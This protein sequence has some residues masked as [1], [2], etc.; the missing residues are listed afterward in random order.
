MK[1]LETDRLILRD[2]QLTDLEDLYTYA[3]EEG[4]GE[5]A[6]WPHHTDKGVSEKILKGFIEQ[7]DVYALEYKETGHVIGSLGIHAKTMDQSYKAEVQR[8]IG[9]VM[10]KDYWGKGLMSEA[11]AAAITYAFET[12][13]VDVLWC[14]YF[15]DNERSRRVV[16]KSGFSYYGEGVYE[17]H[18]LEKSFSMKQYILTKEMYASSKPQVLLVPMTPM[19]FQAYKA[20]SVVAYA[21]EKVIA[22]NWTQDEALEKAQAEYNTLLPDNE[23]TQGHYLWDIVVASQKV[24][25]LWLGGQSDEVAF[26]YAIDVDETYRRHGYARQAM[27]QVE[28]I[29][30]D[31]GFKRIGLHVFGSNEKAI[32]LYTL[33]GYIPTNIRMEKSIT[34]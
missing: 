19:A 11:V 21:K 20:R 30:R 6:G 32:A 22:G 33:L 2:W 29:A 15:T 7:G 24:G 28:C 14:G 34:G 13:G 8:E 12:M 10:S 17:A 31:K 5:W 18:L 16:E 25:V 9:Y 27:Q 3:K 26:I 23:Q 1:T 4:V